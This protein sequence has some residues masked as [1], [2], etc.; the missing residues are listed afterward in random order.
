VT[1]ASIATVCISGSLDE[2]ISA[3]ARA[4]FDGIELFEPDLIAS[5]MSPEEVRRRLADQGLTLDLYQPLRDI[6]GTRPD[7][8]AR[9]LERARRKFGLMERLGVDTV[10]VCSNVATATEDAP[11]L[12][13]EQL[14]RLADVAADHGA[15]V[16]YEALAWGAFVSTY[17]EA[18]EIVEA[19]D[20]PA[21]GI[22]LDSF[23]ILSRGSRL[24]RIADIPGDKI[25]YLQLADAPRLSLDVLS[26]SRHHRLFPGE[27]D[28]DLATFTAK[29]LDAG[30]RGPLSL[31]VFNDVF[32][33]GSAAVTARDA[34]R[35]LVLLEEGIRGLS[36]DHGQ[37]PLPSA[38]VVGGFSFVEVQPGEGAAVT[39]VLGGLG[40]TLRGPH[41]RK[42]VQL[43][44]QG[45]AR[46]I[47]NDSL[48]SRE[49]AVVS[50]G[51]E[52]DGTADVVGRA[53][54]LLIPRV[55]RDEFPESEV[56]L[57][58]FA[59]PDG[60]VFTTDQSAGEWRAEFG[61]PTA[62]EGIGITDIDHVALA[63]PWQR[64][65]ETLLFFR[66]LFGLAGTGPVDVPSEVGL[67]SSRVLRSAAATPARLVLNVPPAA[68]EPGSGIVNH[69]ALATIDLRAAVRTLV[70]RGIGLLEI[71][72]NYYDDLQA[73]TGLA[74]DE[75]AEL[76]DL[77]ILVDREGD[78]TF[79]HAYLR[80]LGRFQFELVQRDAGYL[81]FGAINAPVRLAALRAEPTRGGYA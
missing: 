71:P 51:L 43:W 73:R 34:R 44:E 14:S 11:E 72:A 32:R 63:M 62:A 80:P 46:V 47:V 23:H 9:A 39:D 21:L 77:G 41:R 13:I 30:Y 69:V 27:G 40:F 37:A 67:I 81:G 2:K 53:D 20:H 6:E 8:F 4:R 17:D 12:A 31:E 22:C 19:A 25:F 76:S 42:D 60:T 48:L 64:M 56:R 29:V 78:E 55:P 7:E 66:G 50:V 5:R 38:P 15:R 33:Q 28:W 18:W 49:T 36:G 1:R 24:D 79:L 52:Q 74:D 61:D 45:R 75:I 59:A 68:A 3:I 26:W 35:S 58:G 16:A 65:P 57:D 54:A 10:L 70:T